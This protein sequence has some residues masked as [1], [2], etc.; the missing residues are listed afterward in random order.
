MAGKLEQS[1]YLESEKTEKG[2][3]HESKDRIT[4]IRGEFFKSYR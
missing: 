2:T 1:Q 4:S 3:P